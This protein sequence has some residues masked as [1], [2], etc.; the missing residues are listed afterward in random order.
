MAV[1][2][3]GGTGKTARHLERFL[4][5]A[6]TPFVLTSRRGPSGAPEG[7]SD[8]TVKFDMLDESTFAA[9][10]AYKFQNGEK[11]T[12]LYLI[13][14]E[15]ENPAF[16][17]D[18]FIDYVTKKGVK[19]IVMLAGSTA[20]ISNEFVADTCKSLTDIGL[21]YCVLRPTWFNGIFED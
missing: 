20:E 15:C 13:A 8:K 1:L 14:P 6:N 16:V 21:E 10:F 9:P 3:T 2:I 11:I 17:A 19:R 5:N 4:A 12:S 7:L 18:S